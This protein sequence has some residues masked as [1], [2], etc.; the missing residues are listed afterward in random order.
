MPK[1]ITAIL[2]DVKQEKWKKKL[3]DIKDGMNKYE[4]GRSGQS[5]STIDAI[6]KQHLNPILPI[7]WEVFHTHN[8]YRRKQ[9]VLPCRDNDVNGLPDYD[10]GIFLVGF[11]SLPI[12]LSLA[13]IQPREQIYFLYSTDTKDMLAE[14][15]NRIR[16]MLDD[17]NSSLVELVEDVVLENLSDSALEI[18]NPSDPVATFK[19]I[20]EVIDKVGNKSI[21]LDLTGGKKTMIGGGFTA[22]AILTFADSRRPAACDMFYIDSLEYDA[23]SGPVPGTEFLSMLENPYDVY[24]VQSIREAEKLFKNHNY[25]AAA[26]LWEGVE[27]KLES[28]ATRY[29]LEAEKEE[30]KN[31]RRMANCYYRWDSFYYDKAQESQ[32]RHGS[33]WGYEE[34]HVRD[35]IDVL[36]ILSKVG[37]RGTLFNEEARII[38]YG[39][40]RYQNAIRRKESGKLDDAIVRFTQ[41][42]EILCNYKIYQIAKAKNLFQ[43]DGNPV[44]ITPKD[45]WRIS[46]LI[47]F[48]FGEL[49]SKS[50]NPPNPPQTVS[51]DMHNNAY[52]RGHG[53]YCWIKSKNHCL[54]IDDYGCNNVSEITDLIETRNDFVHFNNRMSQ[55]QTKEN[56]GNLQELA[57]KFLEKFS[58]SYCCDNGLSFDNLL[59]LHKFRQ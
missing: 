28:H 54:S 51:T 14:I 30:T 58:C 37:N 21:A 8:I 36:N 2:K 4:E 45:I 53:F 9:N 55:V 29:G 38:H 33:S 52:D 56:A 15:G 6:V 35:S 31:Q 26:V 32:N 17:C 46:P 47:Q 3:K 48:L 18:D 13:E 11:S 49:Q 40:D 24:N 12:V 20:K 7:Y 59:K 50:S 42:I 27:K 22:G 5:S 1:K 23:D 39:V 19:R 41:V 25:E 57:R 43:S 16:T 34:K 44:N 10:V